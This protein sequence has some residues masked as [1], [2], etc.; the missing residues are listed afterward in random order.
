MI[1]VS[2]KVRDE[3]N[4]LTQK[5]LIHEEGLVLSHDSLALKAMVE[6]TIANFKGQ[7]QDV[8]IKIKF[9]W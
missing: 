7:A 3:Q 8:I 2:V 6:E 1:E 4:T 9:V 5:Y